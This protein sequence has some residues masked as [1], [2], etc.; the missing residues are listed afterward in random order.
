MDHSTESSY[1]EP[2]TSIP[3]RL[4]VVVY[5]VDDYGGNDLTFFH[6]NPW[7]HMS[8]FHAQEGALPYTAAS[9]E[10][11]LPNGV[12]LSTTAFL[13]EKESL[14]VHIPLTVASAGQL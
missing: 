8:F 2:T 12:H 7:K 3:L 14:W 9:H 10:D 1:T 6:W 4:S 13:E 5:Q 11:R